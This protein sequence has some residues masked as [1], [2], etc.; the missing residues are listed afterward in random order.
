MTELLPCP[1]CGGVRQEIGGPAES[2]IYVLC[3]CN[4]SSST[5]ESE[6][7]A[8]AAWNTRAPVATQPMTPE[9]EALIAA[10][11]AKHESQWEAFGGPLLE[12]TNPDGPQAAALI[13]EQ[14]AEIENLRGALE[15]IASCESHHSSDVVAVARK[16]LGEQP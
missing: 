10:L 8:I 16:A 4:A 2:F 7:C 1:F 6:A 5:R 12:L 9:T 13:R 11:E 15:R 14:A 3:E